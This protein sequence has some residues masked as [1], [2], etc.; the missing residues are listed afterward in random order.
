MGESSLELPV[1]SGQLCYLFICNKVSRIY[2]YNS[3]LTC[4]LGSQILWRRASQPVS[5]CIA[6][7]P[8]SLKGPSVSSLTA[9]LPPA[10]LHPLS[11]PEG[12]P[13]QRLGSHALQ[14]PAPTAVALFHPNI[15]IMGRRRQ[16]W[17]DFPLGLSEKKR[18]RSVSRETSSWTLWR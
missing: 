6:V 7:N 10:R 2:L 14:P 13:I 16:P 8:A 9:Q 4:V 12:C 5:A 3:V 11:V 17:R 18:E 15:V 1:S